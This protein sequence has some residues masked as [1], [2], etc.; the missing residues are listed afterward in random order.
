M[1]KI[2]MSSIISAVIFSGITAFA[3]T[4]YSSNNVMY[5]KGSEDITVKSALDELYGKV[6]SNGTISLVKSVNEKNKTITED[7]KTI[8]PNYKSLTSD[9]FFIKFTSDVSTIAGVQS[10]LDR[11]T[12][13]GYAYFYRPTLSYDSETG[14]LTIYTGYLRA[15]GATDVGFLVQSNSDIAIPFEVYMIG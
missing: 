12:S 15:I 1:K 2:I 13:R 5:K 7:I 3:I 8:S 4:N 11:D 9:S 6:S 10:S 14:I